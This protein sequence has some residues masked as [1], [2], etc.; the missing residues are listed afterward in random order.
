VKQIGGPCSWATM[1]KQRNGSNGKVTT[2]NCIK[3]ASIQDAQPIV[4]A[5]KDLI[6][7]PNPVDGSGTITLVYPANYVTELADVKIFNINGQLVQQEQIIDN[8]TLLLKNLSKGLYMIHV[9]VAGDVMT[10]KL[11]VK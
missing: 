10:S 3:S 2:S 11:I 6:V 1:I 9:S 4:K 5:S 7:S 8:N